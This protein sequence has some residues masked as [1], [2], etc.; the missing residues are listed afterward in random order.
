MFG[1]V[2]LCRGTVV[3]HVAAIILLERV[4]SKAYGV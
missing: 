1:S 3:H 2:L 4:V